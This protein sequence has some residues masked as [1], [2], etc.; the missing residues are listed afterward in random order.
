MNNSPLRGLRRIQMDSNDTSDLHSREPGQPDRRDAELLDA[1]SRA[2]VGVVE[3]V[4]PA[5]IGIG[6]G[7]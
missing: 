2:V 5:V 7:T 6:H 1:Y 3:R 4:S